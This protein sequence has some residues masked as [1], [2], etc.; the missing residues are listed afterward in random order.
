VIDGGCKGSRVPAIDEVGGFFLPQLTQLAPGMVHPPVLHP[1]PTLEKA[2]ATAAIS[3]KCPVDLRMA[4]G[5][6]QLASNRPAVG[7]AELPSKADSR[8]VLKPES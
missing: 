2:I 5:P 8:A 7:E 4:S 6:S 3:N 1:V